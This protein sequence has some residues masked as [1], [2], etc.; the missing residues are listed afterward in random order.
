VSTLPDGRIDSEAA[1]AEWQRNT[2]VHAPAVAHRID[3]DDEAGAGQYTKARAI[4][5]QY[6]VRLAKLE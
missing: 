6:K 1:D 2:T 3:I 5:E 4:L